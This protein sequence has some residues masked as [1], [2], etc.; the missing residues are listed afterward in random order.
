MAGPP[1]SPSS[2]LSRDLSCTI[3]LDLFKQPVSLPCDHTFCQACISAYWEDSPAR[4]SCPQ[5]RAVFPERSYRPNRLAA[6]IVEAYSQETGQAGRAPPS[7]AGPQPLCWRHQ[8]EL[9][10]FC[11]ED[12]E[13][14]CLVC[15]LSQEH[16]SHTLVCI[17]E[18]VRRQRAVLEG[19]LAALRQE[20]QAALQCEQETEAEVKK[21]KEQTT[22]MKG[23][24]EAQFGELHQFLDQ[25][26]RMLQVQLKTE[27]RR[28]LI[29]L[30]ERKAVLSLEVSR[31]QR[32]LGDVEE[33]L[34]QQ[35]AHVLLTNVKHLLNRPQ[36]KFEKPEPVRVGVS[37][38]RFAGPLQYRVW[39]SMTAVIHP[40]PAPITLDPDTANPWLS[41]SPSRSCVKYENHYNSLPDNPERFNP[42]LS[43]LGSQGFTYGTHYWE[44]EVDSI[45]VW[46]VGVACES[47]ARKGVIKALPA[48]GFWTLSL[49]YGIQYMAGT[50]PPTILSLEVKPSKIGVFLDCKRGLVSFYNA[51]DMSHVYTFKD[52]FTE[53][54]FPYFNLGFLD[55]AITNE[56]LKVFLP[57]V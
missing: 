27:E 48:N 42:A 6:N 24:I 19:C 45:T 5:C 50:A 39:K 4:A 40:A 36:V 49:S 11:E 54:L 33:R 56:P 30:D 57:Q 53:K 12:Q 47:V 10:M 34:R 21:L 52:N 22:D 43:L 44:V 23:R 31:L 41:L 32:A 1:Q 3:C 14:V 9:K 46:T 18:A 55:K 28:A 35:D 38:G 37:E 15:G 7:P 2:R 13:L 17:G 20:V 25:E 51:D 8:E 16:R 26:E 29:Q